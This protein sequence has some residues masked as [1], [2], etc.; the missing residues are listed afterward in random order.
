MTMF[1]AVLGYPRLLACVLMCASLCAAQESQ[2]KDAM[3]VDISVIS[4]KSGSAT[5]PPYLAN[6]GMERSVVS[7]KSK[8]AKLPLYLA[9]PEVESLTV[10][11]KSTAALLPA[12]LAN[13]IVHNVPDTP[14]PKERAGFWSFRTWEDPPL[15]TN[16]QVFHDKAWIAAQSFWLG[17]I[18]YDVELTHEGL[19]HHKCVEGNGE[20]PYP[21][22]GELYKGHIIE[23]AVGTLVNWMSM[24]YVGKPLMF[25]FPAYGSYEHLRGGTK[26]LTNCW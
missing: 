18:V 14:Q 1:R 12:Y 23:Y 16:A 9:N 13:P 5:L 19:A 26:W 20:N 15:R 8:E 22:R 2:V 17:S 11:E 24:R 10:S 25:V 4:D 21:S 6:Q 7:E 3:A